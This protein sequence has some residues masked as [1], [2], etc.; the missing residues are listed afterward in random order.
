MCCFW[1]VLVLDRVL[2]KGELRI[3]W[4]PFDGSDSILRP[5]RRAHS[6]PSF[7]SS[8]SGNVGLGIGFVEQ[9]FAG[10][11]VYLEWITTTPRRPFWLRILIRGANRESVWVLDHIELE[12]D[13]HGWRL[14][15]TCCRHIL[16]P[17]HVQWIQKSWNNLVNGLV[18]SV[19]WGHL[20]VDDVGKWIVVLPPNF[21]LEVEVPR[22]GIV[23]LDLIE[24]VEDNCGGKSNCQGELSQLFMLLYRAR[25]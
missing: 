13:W 19:R 1:Y 8:S 9:Q 20:F 24:A 18:H 16:V 5:N 21:V 14:G 3:G 15:R 17:I 11:G 22:Y 10:E 7:D 25:L 12:R 23:D 2:S 6:W 4:G